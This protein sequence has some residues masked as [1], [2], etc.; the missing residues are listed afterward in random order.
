MLS[1]TAE[2]ALRA[3]AFLAIEPGES[4]TVEE[5][6]E[7]TKV[8]PRYL[9][10]VMQSLGRARIVRSQRGLHGGFM[11][12]QPTDK[13]TLLDVV[14]AID[15]V[16]RIGHCP[17]GLPSHINLCPLHRRLDDAIRLIEDA[18]KNTTI[19]E[20]LAEK[21]DSVPLCDIRNNRGGKAKLTVNRSG[22]H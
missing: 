13:I 19:A 16:E 12:A 4:K 15:P 9:S 10:K 2:Y 8:P 3:V 22:R 17:L 20:I 6:A 11:L 21:G 18:L 7:M 14:N 1:Q 5:A